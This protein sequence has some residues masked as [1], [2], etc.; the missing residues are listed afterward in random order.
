[1]TSLSYNEIFS[2]FLGS[3][4]DY[5]LAELDTSDAYIMMTEYLRKS[6]AKSYIRRLFSTVTMDDEIQTLTFEMSIVVD[7]DGDEEFIKHILSKS[8][9]VEWLEPQVRSHNNT[10][11]AFTSKEAKWFSQ[12]NHL[13]ELRA[14]LEDTKIEVRKSI[15]DR[16]Y[17]YNPYLEKK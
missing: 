11:Q 13:S 10:L 16:G 1:M 5:H 15:R 12:S 4:T 9:I 2:Y 7:E 6:L 14:L 8:M 3:V 17:I